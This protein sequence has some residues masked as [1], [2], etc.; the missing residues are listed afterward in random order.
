VDPLVQE[1]LLPY[2]YAADDPV[3]NKDPGGLTDKWSILTT[4][5]YRGLEIPIRVGTATWGWTKIEVKHHFYRLDVAKALIRHAHLVS[6]GPTTITIDCT[7]IL[8]DYENVF[9]PI[10][11]A[12]VDFRIYIITSDKIGSLTTPDGKITGVASLYPNPGLGPDNEITPGWV[13]IYPLVDV[14]F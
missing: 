10:P 7:E 6:T 8:W 14:R 13:N 1:T 12:A 11:V 2:V 3:S 5:N 9:D 4:A